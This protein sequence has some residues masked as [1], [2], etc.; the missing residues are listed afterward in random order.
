MLAYVFWHRP[1]SKVDRSEYEEA[2]REFHAALG[3]ESA[4]F[5]LDQLPFDDGHGYEDWYLVDDWAALGA[6]KDSAVDPV[7]KAAHDRAA[8]RESIGWGGLYMLVRGPAAIPEGTEWYQKPRR[9]PVDTFLADLPETTIW[10]RQLVL[11]PAPEIC[12]AVD[13]DGGRERIWPSA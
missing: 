12:V 11:G 10:R 3:S 2:E 13:G 5:R 7:R 4:C 1:G 9:V 6:L 8:S